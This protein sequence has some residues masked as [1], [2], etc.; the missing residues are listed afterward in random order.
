MGVAK[1]ANTCVQMYPVLQKS[2][3]SYRS[4]I[5]YIILLHIQNIKQLNPLAPATM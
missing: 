1:M 4:L 2:D 5:I 3:V